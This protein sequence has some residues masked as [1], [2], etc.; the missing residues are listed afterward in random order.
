MFLTI[1]Q[2]KRL[3]R[4][5]ELEKQDVVIRDLELCHVK[6]IRYSKMRGAQVSF[7]KTIFEVRTIIYR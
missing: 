6:N 1:M 4:L 2:D 7:K 3:H 5:K